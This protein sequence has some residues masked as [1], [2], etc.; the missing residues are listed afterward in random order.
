MLVLKD[1]DVAIASLQCVVGLRGSAIEPQAGRRRQ[2]KSA[3]TLQWSGW[4]CDSI[5]E[6]QPPVGE[7]QTQATTLKVFC[8]AAPRRGGTG[9]PPHI[10]RVCSLL[11]LTGACCLHPLA[12]CH[13]PHICHTSLSSKIHGQRHI[14]LPESKKTQRSAAR[15]EAS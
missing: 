4:S 2:T 9:V 5:I 10:P 3:P 13:F 8:V 7:G 1:S 15:I 11:Q 14:C 6:S 12:M